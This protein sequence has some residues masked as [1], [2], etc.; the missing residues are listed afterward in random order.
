MSPLSSTVTFQTGSVQVLISLIIIFMALLM[1]GSIALAALFDTFRSRFGV[2]RW[3]G[4]RGMSSR[5]ISSAPIETE[6]S[7]GG[8]STRAMLEVSRKTSQGLSSDETESRHRKVS[9]P[10]RTVSDIRRGKFILSFVVT[11]GLGAAVYALGDVPFGSETVLVL[12]SLA[13]FFLGGILLAGSFELL[14][15]YHVARETPTTDAA[16]VSAGG[17]VE[18]Y[19]K[20]TV[21][22]HGT[23]KAPFT[24]DECLVC[25]YE[26]VEEP[27]EDEVADSGTAGVPFYLDDGTGEVLVDPDEARLRVELDTQVEVESKEPPSEIT[28]GYV[29]VGVNEIESE[30]RE[31]YIKPGE[32]IYVYG[33]AL[34]TEEAAVGDTDGKNEVVVKRRDEDSLFLIADS[35]EDE[36][37]KSLLSKAAARG[38]MGIILMSVGM[39]FVFWLSGLS[40]PA[41]MTAL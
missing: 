32:N 33:D 25:E 16:E 34:S 11:A 23:H 15:T 6:G 9:S 30:Y 31:R 22:E 20:A 19:G 5:P 26:I 40:I 37:R 29:D 39:G 12:A 3:H 1:A 35:S 24:D 21:S 10:L 8:Y 13:V 28:G 7:G 14:K 36:L 18:L 41:I 17:D 27:G 4:F 2:V 38:A